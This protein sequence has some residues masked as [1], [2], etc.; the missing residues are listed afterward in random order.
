VAASTPI[1]APDPPSAGVLSTWFNPV[2]PKPTRQKPG[3]TPEQSA[4]IAA[5]LKK[6]V[7]NVNVIVVGAAVQMF[8]R[9]P[10]PLDDEEVALL[11]L[12]WE[13][14]IDEMFS[15]AKIKPWHLLLAGNVMIAAAMYVGGTPV[16]KLPPP[17]DP[18]KQAKSFQQPA[19]ITP[20]TP[21]VKS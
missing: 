3:L 11:Q 16:K 8:G 12:G 7:T 19:T 15:R 1:S 6:T 10:A 20:I 14:Y 17:G 2:A 5:G 13:M 21:P 18:A 9:V 4:K